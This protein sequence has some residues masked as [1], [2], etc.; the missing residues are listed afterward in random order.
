MFL[1][2]FGCL[3]KKVKFLAL[4]GSLREASYNS[5]AIK[6]L[7][8][9]SPDHIDIVIGDISQLPLFNSDLESEVIPALDKIKHEL[10]SS[11]GLIISSPEYAHGIS[12]PMK[13]VLDWLVSSFEFPDTK[14]MIINTSPRAHHA[15]DSL[16]EI[17]TTMSGDIIDSAYVSIP[18][19]GSTL[20]NGKISK[21]DDCHFK[22]SE[23]LHRFYSEVVK[24]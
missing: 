20:V 4:S 22:L 1:S 16:K 13:N 9:F 11:S 12:A 18:L 7:A 5:A 23:G 24:K 14:I 21:T 17:L 19:L 15:L 2:E 8:E 10:N 6:S 3:M